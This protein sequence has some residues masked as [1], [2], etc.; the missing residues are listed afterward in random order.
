MK[1]KNIL[2]TLLVG[3]ILA[4]PGVLAYPLGF[5]ILN[6]WDIL[7]ENVFGGFIIAII[8][9][10]VIYAIILM[11]GGISAWS[12]LIFVGTFA[13]AMSIGYGYAI[14]TVPLVLFIMGWAVSR[15][16]QWISGY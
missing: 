2:L 7:V 9:I 1:F 15:I 14:V 8:V 5:P 10:A 12:M 6:L 4:M 3:F 16:A 11:M 13:V